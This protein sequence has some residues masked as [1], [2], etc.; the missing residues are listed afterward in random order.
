MQ[1][2]EKKEHKASASFDLKLAPHLLHL[3]FISLLYSN[4]ESGLNI[5]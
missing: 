3:Q 1:H 2:T 5:N 4:R